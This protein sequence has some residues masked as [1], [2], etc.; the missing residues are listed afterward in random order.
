MPLPANA[1]HVCT[2]VQGYSTVK[3]G[4]LVRWSG[5]SPLP[6]HLSD[7]PV[8]LE[9]CMVRTSEL[10][11]GASSEYASYEGMLAAPPVDVPAPRWVIGPKTRNQGIAIILL[12]HEKRASGHAVAS[13]RA[14]ERA[15]LARVVRL[16]DDGQQIMD[17][18]LYRCIARPADRAGR[19]PY[20]LGGTVN[21]GGRR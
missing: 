16:G 8:L 12:V 20:Q 4:A 1:S 10:P 15:E 3:A 17:R 18:M 13:D 6:M 9:S 2:S 21:A 14:T 5:K 11:G 7:R 19:C